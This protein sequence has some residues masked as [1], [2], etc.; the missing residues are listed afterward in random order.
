LKQINFIK[1][2][3]TLVQRLF[4][5]VIALSLSTITVEVEEEILKYL[6]IVEG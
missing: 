3:N 5:V 6:A 1:E 2:D 4:F